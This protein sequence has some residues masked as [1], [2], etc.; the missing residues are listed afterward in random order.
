MLISDFL[1]TGEQNAQTAK[2]LCSYAKNA[3]VKLSERQLSQAIEHERRQGI[4]ICASCDSKNPGYYLAADK[5]E[6]QRYCDSLRHRAGEIHATRRA[7][8]KTIAHLP[9]REV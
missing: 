2:Q 5:G 7:C 3:G 6:M 9:E 1:L 8:I 4:P